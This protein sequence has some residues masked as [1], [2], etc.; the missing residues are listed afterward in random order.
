METGE[1]KRI[2]DKGF[3]F[4]TPSDGTRDLFFHVSGVPDRQFEALYESQ[5]VTFTVIEGGSK[6]PRAENVRPT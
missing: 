6:G 1:I 4:I 3:G 2:T 5:R